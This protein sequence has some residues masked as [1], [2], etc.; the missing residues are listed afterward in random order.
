MTC[1][2][3]GCRDNVLN[4]AF[5]LSLLHTYV[6]LPLNTSGPK[7]DAHIIMRYDSLAACVLKGP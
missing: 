1:V 4:T 3:Q 7:A 5:R 6:E 2:L